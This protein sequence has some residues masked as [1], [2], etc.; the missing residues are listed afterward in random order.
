MAQEAAF[1]D[2]SP[3]IGLACVGGLV[4]LPKL[5]R[6]AF[7]TRAVRDEALPGRRLP[8]EST[9][10]AALRRKHLHLVRRES[11][12][13]TF[14]DLDGGEASTL[15]AALTHGEGALVVVDD[16]AARRVAA[17]LKLAFTGTAGVILDAKRAGLID[18]ARPLFE[19][20]AQTDFRLSSRIV[21]EVLAELGED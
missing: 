14:P 7:I 17:A 13:P 12:E 21:E 1:V 11:T 16:L 20:L 15:R 4:W 10:R 19:R 18:A 6:A 9:I 5:Y 3:L 2:A 8:G